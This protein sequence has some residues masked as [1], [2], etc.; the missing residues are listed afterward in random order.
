MTTETTDSRDTMKDKMRRDAV[1]L[2]AV[3]AGDL[4]SALAAVSSAASDE[5]NPLSGAMLY[6]VGRNMT[7]WASDGTRLAMMTIPLVEDHRHPSFAAAPREFVDTFKGAVERD[8]IVE[9]GLRG[10]SSLLVRCRGEQRSSSRSGIHR[11]L[12]TPTVPSS[13]VTSLQ[14]HHTWQRSD[15]ADELRRNRCRLGR[16]GGRGADRPARNR[17][18]GHAARGG[19]D[20]FL[21]DP[22][23]V[24]RTV[25]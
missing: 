18:R 7:I 14:D 8:D 12:S 23:S 25:H 22:R 13:P 19:I 21:A 10:Q 1:P 3:R 4:L 15:R 6:A 9:L 16:S 20:A 2:G 11:R 24:Q 17:G 5:E